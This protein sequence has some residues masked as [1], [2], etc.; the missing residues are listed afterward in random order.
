MLQRDVPAKIW[1]WAAPNERVTLTFLNRNYTATADRS[2]NWMITLPAQEA[3]VTASITLKASNTVVINNVLFGDVWLC[4]GQSNMETPVSRLMTKYRDEINSFSSSSIRYVKIPLVYNFHQPQTDVPDCK[5]TDL[6]PV[7]VQNFSG[8]AYFYARYLLEQTGIPQGVINSSVG[9]SPAE[10]WISEDY[11]QEFPVL[12]NAKHIYESDEYVKEIKKFSAMP[13]QFWEEVADRQDKG[14][15][16]TVKWYSPDCDFSGWDETE[17]MGMEWRR[18]GMRVQ[19]GIIWFNREIELPDS[20]ENVE[21]MIY[22]GR[23]VDADSVYINGICV[24]TT[25]YQ[26]PPRNYAIPANVLKAGRNVVTVRL[27]SYRGLPE[28][29]RG[30]SY[31]MVI[32]NNEINLTG[33]WKFKVGT[34]MPAVQ[35]SGATL[36]YQPAG[37]FNSMIAPLQN[38]AIKG[39]V[40]YQGESNTEDYDIYYDL[41]TSLITNWRAVWGTEKPFYFVQ[42]PNFMSASVVQQFSAWAETRDIQFRLSKDVPHTGMAV[43]IDVGEWNDIHP[44]NKKD[45]GIRLALHALKNLYG[46]EI[47]AE[48]PIFESAKTDGDKVILSF[49]KGTDSLQQVSDLRGFTIANENGYFLWA[50]AKIE[51]NTV[52]VWNNEIKT[53]KFVR[54]GWADNPDGANLY[55]VQGLPASPFRIV[56]PEPLL[57]ERD[58]IIATNSNR[59]PNPVRVGNVDEIQP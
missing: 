16:D 44:I 55:N 33:N 19:N 51:G 2:G 10:A 20:L 6:T 36:Q 49:K 47:V 22:M 1:G 18:N 42:L 30:K 57:H 38:F 54:Y 37:L 40:W 25:E 32:N 43:T 56:L 12:A 21:G 3:G 26:Y 59:V 23:I 39:F 29:V 4:S 45:V 8:V 14:L 28:F 35:G 5:W 11:L 17:L 58:D 13:Y 46:K 50:D 9:G 31:K 53:P 52:I 34:I 24:G 27:V 7:S 48:G 41:M 15:N